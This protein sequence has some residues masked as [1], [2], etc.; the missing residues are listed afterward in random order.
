MKL[1]NIVRLY[2]VRLRSRIVPELFAILG[3]AVGVALLFASQVASTSLNGSVRQ[4]TT[5]IVGPMRFQLAARASR[6]FDEHLLRE[7]QR[8]PGVS[9]AVPVL[10]VRVNML[11]PSGAQSVDLL[12]TDPRFAHLGGPLVRRFGYARLAQLQALAVPAP[13]TNAIGA[14]SLRPVTLQAGAVEQAALIGATLT[15]RDIGGL[16]DSPVVLGPLR[17]VQRLTGMRGRLTRI[18]VGARPE[19]DRV[20]TEG[21]TRLAA[22]AL[23]VRPAD[24]DATLFTKAA[25]PTNESTT[26]FSAI[27]AL[28][29][30]L[31]AFNAMLLTVPQRRN[32]V[33]DLRLD[34][35]TAGMIVKVLLFDGVV[36]GI[37]ASLVGLALG[38]IL[39]VEL[40]G[41]NPGYLSLGFPVGS[42]RIVIWQSVAL[43]VAGGMAA[44]CVGV[45]APLRRE[46]A[47]P[48]AKAFSRQRRSA[49]ARTGA[50]ALGSA[51]I[52][53]TTVILLAEPQAAIAGI[54]TLLVALLLL[55][56]AALAAVVTGFDRLR[57]AFSGVS[58]YLAVIELQSRVNRA[59]VLAIA[60][61]GAIAVFGSVAI[62]GAH[63]N[64]QDGL[65]KLAG[66]L[67]SAPVVWVSPAGASN[68]LT[69]AAFHGVGTSALARLQGVR[70][71]RVYRGSFLD[72]DARRLWVIAPPRSDAQMIPPS[73]IVQGDARL[74]AERIRQGGWLAISQA[75][76]AER[77]LHIGQSLTLPTPTPTR[78]RI[79]A[80]TTNFGWP[81]GAVVLNADD[82]ARAWGSSDPSAYQITMRP[83]ASA[84]AVARE[85][86]GMLGPTS[87]LSVATAA[88]REQ[89]FRATSRQ[90]LSRLTQISTL[91]LIAAVLAMGAAM[92]AMIWQRRPQLAD[93]KVDGFGKRVLW[94]SLMWESALLLG[95]G[96]SIGA[97]FGVYGQ[98]LLSH[99]LASVTGFPV[100]FSVGLL[101]AV[102]SFALVTGVAVAI[103]AVPGYL[104]A[105]VRPAISLQD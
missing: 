24:F 61:T 91:V 83:G 68:S 105:R 86:R 1:S 15:G 13:I 58:T 50:F 31:F 27:S 25:G 80:I 67:N 48:L 10:E 100:V 102:S 6:G 94:C 81:P 79:A 104:A 45:L 21:L 99:A 12:G 5:G 46:I 62:Q 63:Q 32:L 73:Q 72:V 97:L 42:Q 53:A 59:R 82:Y 14:S 4:L 37:L 18:F 23:N 36:L 7:V 103:V 84:A 28:V 47:F 71:V 65:D 29:G 33:E 92:G 16:V 55:L 85:V 17:Y 98:L 77:G 76:A 78:L 54:A 74:A 38:E 35:Y 8:L 44:S 89:S 41:A 87:S 20:V 9:A 70:E 90:G 56:P 43:A 2:R 39:S 52:V 34:G 49:T 93:M 96:C 101:V 57:R 11:G 95:A 69:T 75:L 88:Q 3:I 22:G 30:F 19:K 26:L 60:T 40:F 64:L 66:E 51:C